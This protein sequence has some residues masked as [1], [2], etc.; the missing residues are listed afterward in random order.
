MSRLKPGQTL[1]QMTQISYDWKRYWVPRDGGLSFDCDGFLLPPQKDAMRLAWRTTELT[2]IE[3]LLDKPCLI[4]LGEPGIGKSVAIRDAKRRA[5]ATKQRSHT[6]FLFCNL[7]IYDSDV[8]LVKDIFESPEFLFYQREGGELHIF[9]DSF[10]ECLLR[11]DTVAEL[12]AERFGRLESVTNLFLR[13][14]ARTAEWQTSLEDALRK[15]WGRDSIG[16]YELAPLTREQILLAARAQL[17]EPEQFIEDVVASEVVSFAIRPLTLELLIGVW[18]DHDGSLPLTQRDIYEQGCRELCS[19]PDNRQTPKLRRQLS[20]EHRLAVASHVAA[21]MFFCNRPAVWTSNRSSSKAKSDI[22]ISE[23]AGGFVTTPGGQLPVTESALR[24]SLDTGLFTSRGRDRLSWAHQTYGE[25]L[26]ARY[27]A[28]EGFTER[29]MSDLLAHPHDPQR[30]LIPQLREVAA[31]AASSERGLFDRLVRTEPELLLR[32][33]V[34][35]ADPQTKEALVEAVISA[36]AANSIHG[37]WR[38]NR[39]RYRKLRHARLNG[40]L[41]RHLFNHKLAPDARVEVIRMVEACELD[42]LLPDLVR[43]ALDPKEAQRVRKWAAAVVSRGNN[44]EAKSQL[45]PLALGRSGTDA[46]FELRGAG[47]KACWPAFISAREVFTSISAPEKTLHGLY[48]QFLLHELVEKLSVEDMPIALA[49]TETQTDQRHFRTNYGGLVTRILAKAAEHL[50]DANILTPFAQALRVRL[51]VHDITS[52][53][54]AE[55]LRQKVDPSSHLRLSLVRAMVPLFEDPKEDAFFLTR[56]HL[57]IVVPEDFKWLLEQVRSTNQRRFQL[58]YAHLLNWVFY[59]DD[60]LRVDA[61]L[62]AAQESSLLAKV[63]SHWINPMV[64]DSEEA[65][66]ARE[67][68]MQEHKHHEEMEKCAR[69]KPLSPPPGDRLVASIERFES[70]D[71]AAWWKLHVWLEVEAD[72]T[73]CEKHDCM[74]IRNLAGW[75]SAADAT[76]I[77]MIA[78][79]NGYLCA[80]GP[81]PE[82]W[83]SRKNI[84]YHPAVAGFRALL[85]LA[86]EAPHLFEVLSEGV[87]KRWLPAVLRLPHFHELDE[88][89]RM[90]SKAFERVPR[91]AA[92]WTARVVDQENKEGENLWILHKLPEQ[93]IPELGLVMLARARKGRL[94]APCMVQ[95]LTALLDH[96]VAGVLDLVRSFLPKKV[97]KREFQSAV[98]VSSSRLLML[99]GDKSDWARISPLLNADP[100]FGCELLEGFAFEYA[101]SPAPVLKTLKEPEVGALW[102]WMLIQYPYSEDR[103]RSRGG[104]VTTRD[105]MADFRDHL[106]PHL[107]DLGTEAGCSE[108]RRLL[109]NYPQFSWIRPQLLRGQEAIRRNTWI[110]PSPAQLSQLAKNRK[111][112]FVQSSSRLLEAVLDSLSVLQERL[113]GERQLAQFL[114]DNDRPKPEEAISEWVAMHLEDDLKAR[115]VVVGREVQIHRYDRTDIH[116]TAV[117]RN[118]RAGDCENVKVIIEVK[119]CWH[120]EIK[121]AM[122]DQLVERYLRHNDCQCGLYLVGWFPAEIWKGDD[123]RRKRIAFHRLSDLDSYLTMQANSFI[124][125]LQIRAVTLDFSVRTPKS[126]DLR[127]PTS[128]K[129]R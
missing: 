2:S 47:L 58:A 22:S 56:W 21:V 114:W 125:P 29:Q 14:A 5:Q 61:V 105:L 90:V 52:A 18:R 59:P 99:H 116:V 8:L 25:F 39:S 86:N 9:L 76:K 124:P 65:R 10:D 64:L 26:A 53:R 120:P 12:L 104:E 30:K 68:Y 92:D 67:L 13:I 106:I 101:R 1:R 45:R 44:D 100:S 19:D 31:W 32:S 107:A 110:P 122:K 88:H 123:A 24:E 50:E 128:S 66:K 54:L 16:V 36:F 55:S 17:K 82:E 93:W 81:D 74:D 89:R 23:L 77:R 113:Q 3:E 42:K 96:K 46:D 71:T 75:R 83:F 87:W 129:K 84:I 72:G 73:Y 20:A 95:L 85:L 51:Q 78:A 97:P 91:E 112:R 38:A 15:Q 57:R 35:T 33:D 119:G 102:E 98:F 103:D 63:M 60:V 7:G 70:G 94:K 40:Q 49:W 43:L 34:A 115:G 28:Q 117:T 108:L 121:S 37:D 127:R 4:L 118:T 80:C 62:E 69:Q 126:R 27:L 109:A 111:A 48:E 41:R 11:V 6:A 79:A